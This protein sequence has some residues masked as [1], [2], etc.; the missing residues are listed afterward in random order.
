MA[1]WLCDRDERRLFIAGVA[2]EYRMVETVRDVLRA[3]F[4]VVVLADAI[5]P[6]QSRRRP[7]SDPLF[8]VLP[9]GH[10]GDDGLRVLRAEAAYR[11]RFLRRTGGPEPCRASR[12]LAAASKMP[13]HTQFKSPTACGCSPKPWMRLR[14]FWAERLHRT[15]AWPLRW[16]APNRDVCRG[17]CRLLATPGIGCTAL[18]DGDERSPDG[19]ARP[20][21]TGPAARW[22]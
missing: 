6:L 11:P 7:A 13:R 19:T 18:R 14:A 12:T 17:L 15:A 5:R 10:G 3:G 21:R 22:S 4:E 20:G 1:V 16:C 2:T 9:R 8:A